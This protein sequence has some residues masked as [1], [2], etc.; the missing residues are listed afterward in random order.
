MFKIHSM[1]N[2]GCLELKRVVAVTGHYGSGKTNFAINLALNLS[3]ARHKTV[4]I[5]LDVVNPYFRSADFSDFLSAK[6]IETL[7]PIFAN[8][9]LDVPSLPASIGYAIEDKTKTVVLDV[10]GDDA[11]AF[12]LGRFS[13]ALNAQGCTML[14]V[15]N[16][17]RP[18]IQTPADAEQILRD[19]ERASRLRVDALVNNTNLS[20]ETGVEIISSSNGY[21]NELSKITGLPVFCTVVRRDLADKVKEHSGPLY[22]VDIY[23]KLPWEKDI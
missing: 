2:G 23:V 13:G 5:D 15:F 20:R 10:G 22:P 11:G 3:S 12:A 8:T 14:Y 7:S 9:N 19:I 18:L 1:G 4:L 17:R 16:A 21:A 6:G